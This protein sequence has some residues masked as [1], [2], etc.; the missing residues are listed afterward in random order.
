MKHFVSICVW[1][2]ALVLAQAAYS[3]EQP[4]PA[5]HGSKE[6]EQI[7]QLAGTWQ[8]TLKMGD[9]IQNTKILFTVTANGSAVIETLFSGTPDEMI[10]VYTDN[11]NHRLE[12]THYC[13]MGNHPHMSL[14]KSNNTNLYLVYDQG[15]D[16]GELGKGYMHSLNI[17]FTDPQH[18]TENWV[19]IHNGKP[20]QAVAIPLTRVS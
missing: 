8:G 16:S 11:K 7:K 14:R 1:L 4:A 3:T 15:S 12:M 13:A 2:A 19:F 9:K 20:N 5:Y 6:F 10:S 18:I 17:V